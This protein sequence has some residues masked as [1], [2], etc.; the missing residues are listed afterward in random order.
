MENNIKKDQE[1]EKQ[2]N[3]E[4]SQN[5]ENASESSSEQE[6]YNQEDIYKMNMFEQQINQLQKQLDMIK[7][8]SKDIAN[9]RDDLDGIKGQKGK[10]I[11]AHFGRGVYAK[12]QLLSEDLIVDIGGKKF[13]KKD[14]DS[15]KELIEG[16]IG[17]LEEAEKEVNKNLEGLQKEMMQLMSKFQGMGSL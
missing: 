14:I 5:P 12:A 13:V 16:Q 17:K 3:L 7:Q 2:D 1:T 9:L 6:S 10:E 15:T 4:I 11:F 8:T